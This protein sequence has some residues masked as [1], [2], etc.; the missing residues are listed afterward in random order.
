MRSVSGRAAI[1]RSA[2]GGRRAC[3]EGPV[4]ALGYGVVNEDPDLSGGVNARL[5]R[6]DLRVVR[7][8]GAAWRGALASGAKDMRRSVWAPAPVIQASGA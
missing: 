7:R 3:G 8:R 2:S 5:V 1:S 6:Q 4:R